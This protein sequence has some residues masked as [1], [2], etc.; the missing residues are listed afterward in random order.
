MRITKEEKF[1]LCQKHTID[2]GNLDSVITT[3]NLYFV[4]FAH[5]KSTWKKK[6]MKKKKIIKISTDRG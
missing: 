6:F 1:F 3:Y 5:Y 2:G 4:Q